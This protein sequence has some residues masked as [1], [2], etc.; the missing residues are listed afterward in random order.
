MNFYTFIPR[1]LNM[2][3]TA[4]VAIVFVLLV[5]LMLKKAPKVISYAL[6]AVVLF[7]LLCP[8]SIESS[9]SLFGLM[10]APTTKTAT[11]TSS[12]EYVPE[13][14]VHTESPVAASPVAGA[15]DTMNSTLPQGQKPLTNDPLDTPAVVAA[16]VWLIGVL[17]MAAYS[18]V[19][20]LRLRRRLL[21]ASPLRDNIYLADEIASPF[22]MGLIRPKIYL[23]S[24]M[25][26]REQAYI[27]HHEQHHIRR[28]DHIIKALA[29]LALSIHWFNPLVWVAFICSNHDMEMSCDEAVVKKMGDDILADYSASLLNLATGK[30]II[31]GMPL[32][33]GEGNTK[34]RIRNLANWRK[35]AFW[36][37]LI[38]VIACVALAV[39]L[40]TNP[41]KDDEADHAEDGYFLVISAE[42]VVSIEISSPNASGGVINADESAFERGERVWLEQLQGVTDPRGIT[43]TALG[44][45]GEIIYELS[46]PEDA[47]DS[48]ITDIVGSDSWFLA[49]TSSSSSESSDG[50]A[51]PAPVTW[52]YSPAMSASWHAAFYFNFDLANYTH[53]EASCT[54]GLLWN[55]QAEGQPRE[56]TMQFEQGEPLC[57]TP[58][59]DGELYNQ[60]E[61]DQVVFT[62]YDGGEVVAKG[63]LDIKQTG[64]ENG[65][66]FYAALLTGTQILALQQGPD[67]LAS[68]VLAGNGSI[69]SYSDVNHNQINERIIV[70]ETDPGMLYE[71]CVVEDGEV[72]W[73]TEASPAHAGWNTIML[74]SEGGQEYLVEYQPAMFQGVGNYQCTVFSLEGGEEVVKKA[75]AVAFELPVEETPEMEQFANEVGL[76]LRSCNVLLSTE[77]G[78]AVTQ[79]TMAFALPQIYP[80]RFDPDEIQSAIDGTGASQELTSNAASFPNE[81][82]TLLYASGAGAWGSLLTLQPD[83]SFTGDYHDSE[84]GDTAQEYPNGTCYVSI[85]E[86]RF[87]DIQQISDYSWSMTLA[88]LTTENDPGQIWIEDGIRYI[89]SEAHGV[90]NGEEFILYVPGTPAD[91]IPAECRNW[92]PDAYRWR[93]GEIEQLEGWALCDVTAG[94]GFYTSWLS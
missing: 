18:A 28:G 61:Y 4:S 89:A 70:R 50:D 78:I 63:V 87:T 11:M 80:V 67:S 40:L 64:S 66:S 90:A 49:P 44:A 69:V 32:A 3:L 45:D 17:G 73:S 39:G 42:G 1:L 6:W 53:I 84:M 71:L 24:N 41:A 68:V 85:F 43:I 34:G 14:I 58:L 31:A 82:L 13:D 59:V 77:Q 76:L 21:T 25:E 47:T 51:D 72:I 46:I 22:V 29:F 94:I 26:E 20:Y 55:L 57:W 27:I 15:D 12:I 79:Y 7:R 83:G 65:R 2:S 93:N 16:Y 33:F 37:V 30:H 60:A 75:W 35:P 86:G 91:E 38:A 8:V 62:V 48:E 88:D 52:T 56:K 23:P 10:D 81:P 5:R 54:N 9:F 74:Y 36:V 92:W 19:S